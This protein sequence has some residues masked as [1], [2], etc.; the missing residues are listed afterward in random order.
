MFHWMLLSPPLLVHYFRSENLQKYFNLFI[1]I[2]VSFTLIVK[3]MTYIFTCYT[4]KL[5]IQD[6]LIKHIFNSL[7][8]QMSRHD[9]LFTVSNLLVM[10][11]H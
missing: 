10:L 3:N 6:T 5:D 9:K 11:L 1:N 4:L 7:L 8:F 2:Q